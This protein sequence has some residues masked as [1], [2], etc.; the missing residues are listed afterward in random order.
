MSSAPAAST[1]PDV[2][3]H[4][5]L[6]FL[7]RIDPREPFPDERVREMFARATPVDRPGVDGVAYRDDE[8]ETLLVVDDDAASVITLWQDGDRA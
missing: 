3:I 4:A 2:S 7:E 5:A 8:T 1:P 6:R